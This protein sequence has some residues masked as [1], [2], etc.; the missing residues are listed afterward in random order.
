MKRRFFSIDPLCENEILI[1]GLNFVS[2]IF[3]TL[4]AV[5]LVW[6]LLGGG[7]HLFLCAVLS[8]WYAGY[9]FGSTWVRD[10]ETDEPEPEKW[11]LAA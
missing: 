5:F 10:D 4:T 8:G 9:T 11:D 7:N 3:S 1:P 2:L 6:G